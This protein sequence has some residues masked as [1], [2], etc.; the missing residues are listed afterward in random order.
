M[1]A[2]GQPQSPTT[3]RLPSF[4]LVPQPSE[5]TSLQMRGKLQQV[6]YAS[7]RPLLQNLRPRKLKVRSVIFTACLSPFSIFLC[8][9]GAVDH[10]LHHHA[11]G[12][13][14]I[15]AHTHSNTH[16]HARTHTQSC[17][18]RFVTVS[19]FCSFYDTLF[20]SAH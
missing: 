13:S 11:C 10:C 15:Q 9:G 7:V 3:H 14:Y 1:F 5:V 20:C 18:V 4:L 2:H 8:P 19:E 16:T 12:A 17:L 6:F